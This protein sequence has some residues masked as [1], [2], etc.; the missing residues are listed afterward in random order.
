V[1]IASFW[2][3]NF[4]QIPSDNGN[5]NQMSVRRAHIEVPL[6]FTHEPIHFEVI[7]PLLGVRW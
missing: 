4:I 5:T 7:K 1:C 2:C 3:G 6:A